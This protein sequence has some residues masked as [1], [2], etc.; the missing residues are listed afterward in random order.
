M[1]GE[2]MTISSINA[3]TPS[4]PADPRLDRTWATK[5][6]VEKLQKQIDILSERIDKTQDVI[7][8]KLGK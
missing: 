4:R 1:L 5:E 3:Y 7:Y 8:R 2:N 6:E